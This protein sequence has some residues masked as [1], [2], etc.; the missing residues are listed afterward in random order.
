[1]FKQNR[2]KNYHHSKETLEKLRRLPRPWLKN[3]KNIL[4]KLHSEE[5][6]QKI[7]ESL[8]KRWSNKSERKRKSISMQGDY[9]HMKGKHHAEETKMKISQAIRKRHGNST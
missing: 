2:R 5:T 4:G 1:M 6:K 3:N 7:T 8:I 9:N